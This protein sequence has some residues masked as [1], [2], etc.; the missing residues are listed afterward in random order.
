MADPDDSDNG[1]GR[2]ILLGA[3]G[4]AIIVLLCCSGGWLTFFRGDDK[5][6][7]A[8]VAS[9]SPSPSLTGDY[10]PKNTFELPDGTRRSTSP[11]A[12]NSPSSDASVDPEESSQP[13]A[14]VS[15]SPSRSATHK[16]APSKA[17]SPTRTT[18]KRPT[19]AAPAPVKTTKAPAKA[20]TKAPVAVAP[21][22]SP[23]G[24]S[25]T[26]TPGCSTTITATG[27]TADKSWTI[28]VTYQS[29]A[30]KQFRHADNLLHG[31]VLGFS[32]GSGIAKYSIP[33]SSADPSGTATVRILDDYTGKSATT[34][35]AKP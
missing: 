4:M 17:P 22:P 16:D 20:P 13:S 7:T 8:A 30:A 32:N 25:V 12:E 35:W 26:A 3:L 1:N 2:K 34:G 21:V 28:W 15:P 5:S 9:A 14:S 33:C 6:D 31:F 11:S 10:E 29:G 23:K 19:T 24:I 27:M 18:V